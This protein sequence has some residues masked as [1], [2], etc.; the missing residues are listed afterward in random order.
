MQEEYSKRVALLLDC[1]PLVANEPNLALK[2]GTAINFFHRQDFPRLS[3]DIDLTYLPI[4]ERGITLA[5]IENALLNIKAKLE[6]HLA[7][8]TVL[9][10]KNAELQRKTKLFV[11]K[12]GVEIKI[13]PNFSL[14]GSVYPIE[15][16]D[17]A[18]K[19]AKIYGVSLTKVP[20]LSYEDCYAGK[21]CAALDRQHPRD[22][23]DV[24]IMIAEGINEK[25][26]NAFM[27][28]LLSN[29]RP[30]HELLNPNLLNIETIYHHE[31]AGMQFREV[32]L[33]TLLDIRLRLIN[34][35]R[36]SLSDQDKEFILSIKKGKPQFELFPLEIAHLPG[37]RWK[38]MNIQR[39]GPEKHKEQLKKL[40]ALFGVLDE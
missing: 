27:V 20:V 9:A 8:I 26:K 14:R 39:M 19:I 15:T 25:L 28:Y 40:E 13:E 29:N 6:K 24:S 18:P 36:A 4:E 37:I 11:N 22:L 38:L 31:F 23:F 2:G 5:N 34:D 10:T 33:K 1:M 21:F 32:E 16:M 30:I 12:N 17:L 35:L 3:V 7:P